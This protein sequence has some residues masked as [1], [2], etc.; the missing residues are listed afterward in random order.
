MTVAEYARVHGISWSTAKRRLCDGART[1]SE[2]RRSRK[3]MPRHATKPETLARIR[4]LLGRGEKH[5]WIAYECG[6][7]RSTV[8][9]IASGRRHGSSWWE[10]SEETSCCSTR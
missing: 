3:R 10:P 7:G 2:Y 5:E 6:V 9:H 8:T 4:E 1:M